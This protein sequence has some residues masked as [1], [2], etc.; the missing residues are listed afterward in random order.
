MWWANLGSARIS[1]AALDGSG[2]GGELDTT[3]ATSSQPRFL[4]LLQTPRADAVPAVG[5]EPA[6]GSVLSCSSSWLPDVPD[7]FLYRAPLALAYQWSRDGADVAGATDSVYT[8]FAAGAYRC[9]VT[10]SNRAGATSLA[11][12]PRTVTAPAARGG[13]T[14]AGGGG[15]AASAPAAL[16]PPGALPPAPARASFAGSP[17]VVRVNR[18]GGFRFTFSAFG[19][20]AGR[21]AFDSARRVRVGVGDARRRR[22][23]LGRMAFGVRPGGTVTV[24]GRLSKASF[25][26]LKVNRAI[27][28]RITVV[29]T[30]AAGQ[31]T[32]ASRTITL[33]APRP[34]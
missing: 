17:S 25:R 7:G 9:R 4:A 22:I 5:G 19:A 13:G 8:A 2:G 11:S 27:A 30:N 10:A 26:A 34:R 32:T 18:R 24:G 28:T 20:V 31:S 1:W 14:A 16:S 3:G 29:L 23:A 33:R 12:A 6:L 15:A 21:A